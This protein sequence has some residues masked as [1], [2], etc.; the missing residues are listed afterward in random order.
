LAILGGLLETAATKQLER[1]EG[2]VGTV[3]RTG[4][5]R[6]Y[7]RASEVLGTAG[8]AGAV[9]TRRSR[10]GAMLSGAAMIAA[11]AC[12]RWGIFH[13]GLESARDPRST[14]VLQKA[15]L[16]SAAGVPV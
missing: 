13:G 1:R 8:I 15:R 16:G 4:P 14:V 5:G 9:V 7:L 6:R 12:T 10:W 3:Y 2:M 11:S